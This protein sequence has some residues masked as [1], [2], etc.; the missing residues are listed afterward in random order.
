[1]FSGQTPWHSPLAWLPPHLPLCL[2]LLEP[3]TFKIVPQSSPSLE[4]DTLKIIPWSSP[5]SSS[6]AGAHDELSLRTIPEIMFEKCHWP[7][8]FIQLQLFICLWSVLFICNW[9][10]TCILP[11]LWVSDDESELN[12]RQ[13]RHKFNF[14]FRECSSSALVYTLMSQWTFAKCRF[15]HA[16]PSSFAIAAKA[17]GLG[18]GSAVWPSW[19]P[20]LWASNYCEE[21]FWTELLSNY[22]KITNVELPIQNESLLCQICIYWPWC[23]NLLA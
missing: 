6:A 20:A 9:R 12:C 19:S 13:V 18:P 1:M 3:D 14:H 22:C 16:P 7:S 21:A 15:V 23:V 17:P 2:P 10:Y 11:D 5:Q 8:F 4:S